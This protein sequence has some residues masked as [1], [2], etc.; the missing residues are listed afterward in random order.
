MQKNVNKSGDLS[1]FTF[2]VSERKD[3]VRKVTRKLFSQIPNH[4]IG[5]FVNVQVSSLRPVHTIKDLLIKRPV[6][7]SDFKADKL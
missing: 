7:E 4:V 3:R 6:T 5:T 2:L 1:S